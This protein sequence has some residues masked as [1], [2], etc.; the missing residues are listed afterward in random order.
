VR[1]HRDLRIRRA[2]DRYR[3]L[4]GGSLARVLERHAA[5]DPIADCYIA[6]V[7]SVKITVGTDV[8]ADVPIATIVR[9]M[10]GGTWLPGYRTRVPAA[11]DR[12]MPEMRSTTDRATRGGHCQSDAAVVRPRG[13]SG[14]GP[15]Q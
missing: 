7:R 9:P 13:G 2:I 8:G 15:G 11:L 1:D 5:A 4:P 6:F 10:N 12:R 14:Q 3:H